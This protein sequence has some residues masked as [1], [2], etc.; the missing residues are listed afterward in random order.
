MTGKQGALARSCSKCSAAVRAEGISTFTALMLTNREM[1]ELFKQLDPMRCVDQAT[2]TV[3]IEVPIAPIGVA[4]ALRKLLAIA[5]QHDV[6]V[7][8]LHRNPLRALG[9]PLD[10]YDDTV[11]GDRGPAAGGLIAPLEDPPHRSAWTAPR[12]VRCPM[13]FR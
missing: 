9:T 2:G 3:E 1:M 10:S 8:L 6:A 7:P 12:P 5:A 4:P 13:R 11:L